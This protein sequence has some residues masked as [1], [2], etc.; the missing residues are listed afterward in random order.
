VGADKVLVLKLFG[1]A[2]QPDSLVLTGNDQRELKARLTPLLSVVRYLFVIKTLFFVG[3]DLED[4]L[5]KDLYAEVSRGT[6]KYQR[7]GYA[8]C[9]GATDL[10]R[11]LWDN[12]EIQLIE[13]QPGPFLSQLQSQLAHMP[14]RE[15]K[16]PET[17]ELLNRSPYKFLYSFET[18]DA[19][20]FFGRETESLLLWRKILSYRLVVL[21]G[22]SGAGKTSLLNAGVW[23]ELARYDYRVCSARVHTEP[24]KKVREEVAKALPAGRRVGSALSRLP[25]ADEDLSS[26][27]SR[28]LKPEDRMGV[29]LDQFEEL[30]ITASSDVQDRFL[31]DLAA[32]LRDDSRELRFVLSMRE[33]FL[34][35][36][37]A[38]RDRLLQHYANSLRLEPLGRTAA[39][40]AIV[41]PARRV[42]LAYE[43]DLIESLL[44]D[45]E[46][47]GCISPPQL[48]IVCDRLYHHVAGQAPGATAQSLGERLKSI[49]GIG[50]PAQKVRAMVTVD[51]YHDLGGAETIL[52]K[53]VD[54]VIAELPANQRERARDLLKAMITAEET[55]AVLSQ[56]EIVARSGVGLETVG[57]V[58]KNLVDYRLVRRM[59]GE[60]GPRYE[61]AHEHLI[62]KIRS[63][64]TPEEL[65]A[66]M[67][68][69]LLDQ[70][71][72]R[73]REFGGLID[74]ETLQRINRQREN[75]YLTITSSEEQELLF[76]SVLGAGYEAL[77]WMERAR[78]GGVDVEEMLRE[79]LSSESFRTRAAAVEAL[80]RL[81]ERFVD[82]LVG[83]LGDDYPQVRVAAIHALER[84]RPDGAWREHLQYECYVPAGP[85]IMGVADEAHEV[86][87]DAYYIGKYPVTNADYKR[88]KDDVGQPF[89]IPQGKADHPVVS[90]SWYDAR[91]YAAWAGMRLLTEAEWEKAASAEPRLGSSSLRSELQVA[92]RKYPWGD[93]FDK[94]K[95]NTEE[96]GIGT[97][98]PVGKYSPQGD[99]AYGCADMAGNVWEWTS[100]LRKQYPYRADDG[101]EDIS[102]DYN[103]VV[104]GG[105]FGL[106]ADGARCASRNLNYYPSNRYRGLGFRV[107]VGVVA[108]PFSPLPEA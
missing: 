39:E 84:L 73:Y 96:S 23:P 74:S 107:G 65:E 56:A 21:F 72:V 27:F 42:G 47:S 29:L 44:N 11:R 24:W 10:D 57:Q 20:I 81:G 55:K 63:W 85:F 14:S 41:E 9:P 76:R 34:P 48:Q 64:V 80:G 17:L 99:S 78:N 43:P 98:T 94:E 4:E 68:R 30:F 82:D 92:K 18:D 104:R 87:L 12:K 22:P 7:R 13:A 19:E 15:T 1:N 26:Y 101:R 38:Y 106:T 6:G 2:K 50:R 58:L 66:E 60:E 89:E 71:M 51:Q 108:A 59:G 52:V 102:S 91:D 31:C 88:Y 67:V 103:R 90:V 70:Q 75:P 97:T 83:V 36:L 28:L 95:C 54:E 100:S 8:V 79:R 25:Q 35:R 37:E 40:L 93:E 45:L 33:D 69:R 53:Y 32:C 61:L 5:F 3:Y 105:S 77:Y 16:E 49:L 86:M 62:A 46:E